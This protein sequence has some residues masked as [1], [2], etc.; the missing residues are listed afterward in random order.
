MFLKSNSQIHKQHQLYHA[1]EKYF[2]LYMHNALGVN[3]NKSYYIYNFYH[4][5][6][7]IHSHTKNINKQKIT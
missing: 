5:N 6:N 7:I 3:F 4:W 1:H 2:S